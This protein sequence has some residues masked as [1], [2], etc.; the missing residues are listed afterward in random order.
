MAGLNV[1]E[2]DKQYLANI[3]QMGKGGEY[4]VKLTNEKGD[5]YTK[6]LSDVTQT[7]LGNLI[8]Q[9]KE[10]PKTLEEIARSQLTIDE[11]ILGDVKALRNAFVG[12]VTTSKQVTRGI[13]GVQRVA[14]TTL[15]EYSGAINAKDFR[16]I[17]ESFFSS[18]ETVGKDIKEG[19][20]SYTDALSKGLLS[21][22][23]RLDASEKHF[24]DVFKKATENIAAKLGTQT[25]IDSTAKDG[26]NKVI[27]SYNGRTSPSTPLTNNVSNRFETLQNTQ[28]TQTTQA[29]KGTVD[30]GGKITVDIQTPTGMSTEQ[31]KQ[32]IDSV[33]N[34][35]RF[36]DYIIRLTTPSNLKEPTSKT[37]Q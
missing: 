34:D 26:V 32:F 6:K 33:F 15:G 9:Q 1:D 35:P 21:F 24:G 12:G 13:A 31:S 36:K 7:E 5:E 25:I 8:K 29:S 3:A 10:G 2:E 16:D 22:A 20:M 14:K 37:Y 28:V 23:D 18:V 11:A 27:E 19:N 30:V 4:E 17:S